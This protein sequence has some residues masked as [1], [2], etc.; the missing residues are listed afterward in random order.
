MKRILIFLGLK[1]A[2]IGG[3]LG[4]CFIGAMFAIGFEK[5]FPEVG[6]LIF[7]TLDWFY[8]RWWVYAIFVPLCILIGIG[9]LV[10]NWRKAGDLAKR[11]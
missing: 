7:N 4:I 1:V 3:F 2:E 11:K 5:C 6:S 9:L 10:D 8:T